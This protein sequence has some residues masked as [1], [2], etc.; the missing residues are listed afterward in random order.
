MQDYWLIVVGGSAGGVEAI[1]NLVAHL[2]AELPAALFVVIHVAPQSPKML[3]SILERAGRLPADYPVDGEPIQPGRIYVAQPDR[4]LLVEQGRV[5]V[6]YGPKENRHRPAIDP[7]FRSAAR[8]YGERVIGVVLTGMLDDGTAGLLAIKQHGGIAVVQDPNEAMYS[9]MPRNA[10]ANVEVDYCV[11]L[12]NIAELLVDLSQATGQVE[13][14]PAMQ[15]ELHPAASSADV[16]AVNWDNAEEDEG[17]PSPFA[18]P[19][20][21][22]ILWE[23]QD[24]PLVR[25]RC[26]IGHAFSPDT[27]LES[28]IERVEQAFWTTLRTLEETEELM[29]RLADQA[30]KHNKLE[31]VKQL[32][33]R[34]LATRERAGAMRH[35][36]LREAASGQSEAQQGAA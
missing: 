5:R 1:Q 19:D 10:M 24:G 26:R 11:P 32:E 22:G 6:V 15:E 18:C 25:Y 2:P 27:F 30:R 7:L 14:E 9:D 8:A 29:W 31:R 33:Q 35:L 36:L 17:K 16:P 4:H 23:I 21:N 12:S 3:A 20:C 28:Q 34:A 13:E